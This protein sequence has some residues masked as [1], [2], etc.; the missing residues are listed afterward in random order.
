MISESTDFFFHE[1]KIFKV[2]DFKQLEVY[3]R[4]TRLIK[5]LCIIWMIV[6]CSDKN[7]ISADHKITY[8][9]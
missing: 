2:L 9:L 3:M 4:L 5:I 6:Q 7:W 8:Y 1:N